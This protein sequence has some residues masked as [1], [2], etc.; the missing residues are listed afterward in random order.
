ME[1]LI[2]SQKWDLYMLTSLTGANFILAIF[3][4]PIIGSYMKKY[5]RVFL[6]SSVITCMLS[7]GLT[8]LGLS[9]NKYYLTY[10]G[11]LFYGFGYCVT[12][13]TQIFYV[14]Q[15]FKHIKKATLSFG[16]RDCFQTVI[17]SLD[18]YLIP[19]I[20]EQYG[21]SINTVFMVAFFLNLF[22]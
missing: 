4:E 3:L 12:L 2:V 10:I 18:M 6:Y 17:M 20:Y 22:G 13:N 8:W 15:H 19:W 14:N 7:L 5:S 21:N 9:Q 16:V 11:Q 1:P